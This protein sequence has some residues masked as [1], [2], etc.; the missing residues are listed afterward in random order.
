MS[1]PRLGKYRDIVRLLVRHGGADLVRQTRFEPG[2][3]FDNGQQRLLQAVSLARVFTS[4][5]EAKDFVQTLPER[6][7]RILDAL[8]R[9]ELRFKMEM[10][11]EGAAAA[12]GGLWL[13]F[14][15]LTSDLNH[16]PRVRS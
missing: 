8:A 3:G 2:L 6:A 5:L 14:R 15:I 10:I 1:Q 7:N 9:N 16:G 4:V 13:S 12:A 11:D